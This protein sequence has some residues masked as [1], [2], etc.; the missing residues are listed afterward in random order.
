MMKK[1]PM[2]REELVDSLLAL[3]DQELTPADRI[4]AEGRLTGCEKYSAYV[5]GYERTLKLVLRTASETGVSATLPEG[6]VS[7]IVVAR[8]PSY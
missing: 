4:R 5:R 3:R 8:Y 1:I 6:L 2:T 7:R